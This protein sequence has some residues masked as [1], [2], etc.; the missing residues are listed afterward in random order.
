MMLNKWCIRCYERLIQMTK[1][2]QQHEHYI[3]ETSWY[4]EKDKVDSFTEAAKSY[5]VTISDM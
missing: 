3:V 5:L 4:G 2:E 1:G